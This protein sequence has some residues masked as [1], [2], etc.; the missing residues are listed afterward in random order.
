MT[1]PTAGETWRP[2][3]SFSLPSEMGNDR[4]AMELVAT[5]VKGMKLSPERLE[6][7]KTAVAEAALNGIEHGNGFRPDLLLRVEVLASPSAVMVRV[8]DQGNTP[9]PQPPEPDLEAKLAG[10]Q[11]PRGWGLFLIR[12]M[13][14]EVRIG[15]LE[16]NHTVELILYSH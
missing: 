15:N 16:K 8:T 6:S 3:L 1:A 2:L 9:I 5:A 14:D 11:P 10:R 13:V 4:V 7:L 12:N